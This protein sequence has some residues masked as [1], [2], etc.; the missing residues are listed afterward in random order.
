[1][2]EPHASTT[3]VIKRRTWIQDLVRKYTVFLDGSPV[4]KLWAFQTGKYQV[5]PG[6]HRIRLGIIGTG[7]A[8]SADVDVNV[9]PGDT[10][11]LRTTGRGAANILKLP[12]ALP[13]GAA[14]QMSGRPI[15]SRYYQGP[16]IVLNVEPPDAI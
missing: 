2:P 12:F 11:V 8:S 14:A 9:G 5:T 6:T 16:W 13:A 15:K 4:D 10:V 7:T 1:M 3:I